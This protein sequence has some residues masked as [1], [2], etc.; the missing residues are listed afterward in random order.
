MRYYHNYI[1]LLILLFSLPTTASAQDVVDLATCTTKV[2]KEISRSNK[3]TGKA[4]AG[5]LAKV[6]L[7]KRASGLFVTA[8]IVEDVEGGWIKTAF[9]GAMGIN[10]IAKK[11][12]FNAANRDIMNR[13]VHLRRCLELINN[14][15]DP[16]DCRDRASKSYLVGEETGTETKR[17]V[18]LGD[19]G[20]HTVVE[21]SF[22]STSAT[23][24]PPADLF[25]GDLLPPG[26]RL[27]LNLNTGNNSEKSSGTTQKQ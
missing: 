19:E 24:T 25:K 8:W 1:A 12:V 6:A 10:E 18:W 9:T 11:K 3:W 27:N 14:V 22:G 16:L 21:Y 17:L 23:P 15:N 20:R 5:C 26:V 13:A 7:E 4:P 2:F